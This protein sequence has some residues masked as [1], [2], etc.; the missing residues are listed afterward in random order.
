MK[1]QNNNRLYIITRQDLGLPYC[2]VQGGHALAQY[3]L[4]H[5]S[6]SESWNNQTLIYLSVKN[7]S[8]LK[9]WIRKLEIKSIPHSIFIEPDLDFQI[10][11]LACLNDGILFRDL[12][13]MK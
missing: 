6:E 2:S 8:D 7:E 5:P 11:S 12:K 1:T 9:R 10:T 3:I 13:L 4:E